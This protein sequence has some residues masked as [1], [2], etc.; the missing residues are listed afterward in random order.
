[1]QKEAQHALSELHEV[2]FCYMDPPYNQHPYG[3]NYFMLN[4]IIENKEP[5]N[6]SRVS[7]IPSSWQRSDYNHAGRAKEQLFKLIENC[8]AKYILIS[9]NSEGFIKHHEF[10]SH[11]KTLGKLQ[12]LE[13]SYN[14]FKGSRN[15]RARP[16]QVKEYLFLLEK[17]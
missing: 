15:L 7:G 13:T 1:M 5:T 17:K 6:C 3:S 11:L 16:I 14:T 8:P 9:Y 12:S 2:D 10:T 4:L